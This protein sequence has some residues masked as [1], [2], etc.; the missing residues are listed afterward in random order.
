MLRDVHHDPG[1]KAELE[2]L[3]LEVLP[4]VV[5]GDRHLVVGHVEQLREWLGLPPDGPR[6]E[7]AEL[8]AACDRV[9]VAFERLLAQLPDA[10]LADP[11][12]NRGRDMRDMTVNVFSLMDELVNAIGTGRFSYQAHKE[13]DTG[14]GRFRSVA[15][16]RAYARAVRERWRARASRVRPEDAGALVVT[17]RKGDMTQYQVLDA[18]A[19]HAAGHLRQ[20]YA[21]LRQIGIEPDAELTVE[22]MAPI[23]IQT[24]LY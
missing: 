21:F 7:Y 17:D 22:Q 5:L 6:P 9:L 19:R 10:R 2:A 3:G 15:E 4:V 14:S 16:L 13:A 12:P 8:V 20:A 1:A 23:A 24:S 18:G 11:T